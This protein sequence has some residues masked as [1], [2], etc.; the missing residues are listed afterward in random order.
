M[1]FR[2]THRASNKLRIHCEPIAQNPASLPEWYCSLVIVQRRQFFL[3]TQ[4]TTLF[5][6]W[7]PAAGWSRAEF[8]PRFRRHTADALRD[9]GFA[10]RDIVRIL[11]DGPDFF[12]PSADRA[13][14]GS[15]VDYAKMLQYSADYEGGLDHLSPRA[16]NDIANECPMSK[17]G[18]NRPARYLRQVLRSGGST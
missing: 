1:I 10:D 9:Y 8:S 17:I 12:S 16:M 4:A 3:F 6:L 15:M 18:G 2:L 14:V 5:S 11:D 7:V 13:V